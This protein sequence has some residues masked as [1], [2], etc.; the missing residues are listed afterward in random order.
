MMGVTASLIF[1]YCVRNEEAV[2]RWAEAVHKYDGMD[3][4]VGLLASDIEKAITEEEAAKIME[5][6][7]RS[8]LLCSFRREDLEEAAEVLM[9]ILGPEDADEDWEEEPEEESPGLIRVLY[10]EPGKAPAEMVIT[11]D[12]PTLQELVGG[13][14]EAVYP[15][16]DAALVCNEEGKILGLPAN[17]M[18]G[19]DLIAG[20]FLIA[21]IG[22]EDFIS[23]TDAQV[24]KYSEM[25]KA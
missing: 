12:L 22:A 20:P 16:E 11:R 17:R 13:S 24:E 10:V 4:A 25:F 1:G 2:E 23:L 6:T 14:I 5:P 21:G 18:V 3:T 8:L 15:W 9:S 19:V 7:I